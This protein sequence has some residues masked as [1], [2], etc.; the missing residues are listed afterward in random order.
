[1]TPQEALDVIARLTYKPG[2]ELRGQLDATGETLSIYA[3]PLPAPDSQ[4][5]D[6]DVELHFF[7]EVRLKTLSEVRLLL[8]IYEMLDWAERHE[9]KE[10][11]KYDGV[12]IVD[13]HQTI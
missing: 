5:P 13:P 9:C 4:Q 3:C 6:R 1:M 7:K 12:R 8:L 11:F 2:W 10:W